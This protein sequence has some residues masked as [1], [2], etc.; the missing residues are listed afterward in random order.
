MR[1]ITI[2]RFRY[3]YLAILSS[4]F[5]A[6]TNIPYYGIALQQNTI[7]EFIG[8]LIT[9]ILFTSLAFAFVVISRYLYLVINLIIL[10]LN[11]GG[12]YF[13]AIYSISLSRE[14]VESIFHANLNEIGSN[15]DH[16]IW[17]WGTLLGILPSIWLFVLS[18][19]TTR[20]L[21][22]WLQ[23]IAI[24]IIAISC[25]VLLSSQVAWHI[26]FYEKSL[27]SFMPYNYIISSVQY[28]K[29]KN[30][31]HGDKANH[32]IADSQNQNNLIVVLIIGE[33]ARS[34]HFSLNGY[35]RNT[36]PKLSTINNI[37]SFKNAYSLA[38]YTIGG[39]QSIVKNNVQKNEYS[40]LKLM[41][42]SN[43]KTLWFS[44]QR[45]EN[46]IVTSIAT[47]A[48][49]SLFRD[50]ILADNPKLNHDEVL[51]QYML[52]AVKKFDN[53]NLF[54]TLHTLGSHYSYDL[55]YPAEFR[56]FTPTCQEEHSFFGREH[57]GDKEKIINA[58][59]NSILYTDQFIH[60]VIHHLR[61]RKAL[62]V[63]ISDH[64][65]SL[66]ENGI[67]FHTAAY[68]TAPKEQLHIPMI[69]WGSDKFLA[70][71]KSQRN[72]D[73]A[74]SNQYSTITQKNIFH[75]IPHCIGLLKNIAEEYSICSKQF[76]K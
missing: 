73:V 26:K 50:R 46:D 14:A 76:K 72:L 1:R 67:Y 41:E 54:I 27:R 62:V 48:H 24:H 38:T 15:F 36:N 68:S 58:Y 42:L 71:K 13:K 8:L 37:I 12:A 55:R 45:Y 65:E 75:S 31:A 57:C 56:R 22:L 49:Y 28:L 32:F 53:H 29:S 61:D 51:I 18:K 19:T 34:D 40:L 39:V 7:S 2:Q 70:D 17:F 44:N 64:G 43:F 21:K 20:S 6:I 16:R 63:Y 30:Y 47:E 69:L 60:D 9:N 74:K 33:S 23:S 4:I 10:C 5:V 66:G 35:K 59:D 3:L 11:S 25:Y 52:D